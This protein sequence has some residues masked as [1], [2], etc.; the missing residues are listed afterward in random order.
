MFK[1]IL[2]IS[3]LLFQFLMSQTFEVTLSDNVIG[4]NDTFE[5]T[6]VLNDKGSSFTPPAFSEDFYVL[7]GPNRSSSTRIVNGSMTTSHHAV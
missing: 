5:I 2:I 7:S 6:F 3:L 4:V 1:R